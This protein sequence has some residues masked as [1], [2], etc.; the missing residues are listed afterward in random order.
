MLDDYPAIKQDIEQTMNYHKQFSELLIDE[1]TQ[2]K[3]GILSAND[4]YLLIKGKDQLATY[5]LSK[6][7]NDINTNCQQQNHQN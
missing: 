3:E 7:C 1:I 5:K 4:V 6:V 2:Y